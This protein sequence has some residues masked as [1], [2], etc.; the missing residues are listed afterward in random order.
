MAFTNNSG[1]SNKLASLSTLKSANSEEYG[2]TSHRL[3]ESQEWPI[4]LW[5]RKLW[6]GL[7]AVHSRIQIVVC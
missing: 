1:R 6:N 4:P 3:K 2:I 5:V 7:S